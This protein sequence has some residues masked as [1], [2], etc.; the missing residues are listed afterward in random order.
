MGTGG[1]DRRSVQR[2]SHPVEIDITGTHA[3]L[4]DGFHLVVDAL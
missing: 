2:E 1:E 4:T 3:S